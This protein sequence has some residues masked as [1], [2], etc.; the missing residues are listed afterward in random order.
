[1]KKESFKKRVCLEIIQAAKKY[2]E[3]YLD[4]EYLICSESFI[5]RKYYIV[6]AQK[7]N[8]QHLTGVHSWLS[9]QIFFDKCYQGILS[10]EDF[11]FVK[12]GQNEKFIKGT[13]RRKIKA[14]PDMMELFKPGMLAEENFRKNK[15][16][17]S[18]ATADGSCTL[19]FSESE[20]TRPK[21][22]IKGNA[23]DNPQIVELV[24]RKK[25][26]TEFFDEI[27]IGDEKMLYKHKN[28]IESMLAESLK[29]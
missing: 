6:D 21:S 22:L 28:S 1:M 19:G 15:V 18:F 29:S 7:D 8:F 12:K 9:P 23:L 5:N 24:L 10:E 4:Y 27:V 14:L 2:K 3:T 17:C 11:D 16:F 26:G 25:S 13:V 20:K